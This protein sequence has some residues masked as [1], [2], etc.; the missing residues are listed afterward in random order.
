MAGKGNCKSEREEPES[1]NKHDG[2]G[3]VYIGLFP[4]FFPVWLVYF[5]LSDT[6]SHSD[7]NERLYSSK[8]SVVEVILWPGF[9]CKLVLNNASRSHNP[10]LEQM[11]S[12]EL[13]CNYSILF[14]S[15]PLSGQYFERLHLSLRFYY[16]YDM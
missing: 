1:A 2:N 3:M 14:K 10:N 4:R 15:S 16:L 12:S 7:T 8:V 11:L 5:Y 6:C 13:W 9:L